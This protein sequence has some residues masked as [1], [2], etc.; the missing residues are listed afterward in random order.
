M[1]T[2]GQRQ[3]NAAPLS[4]NTAESNAVFSLRPP[5]GFFAA[6]LSFVL[7]LFGAPSSSYSAESFATWN[8]GFFHSFSVADGLSQSSGQDILQDSL[9]RLWI[10]TQDGLN[11]FTGAGF[12]VYRKEEGNPRS[13]SHNVVMELFED[14]RKELWVGTF[15]G[16]LNRYDPE[17]DS[18]ERF[19]STSPEHPL[20]SDMVRDLAE[21][22]AGEILVAT[23]KGLDLLDPKE[24]K[25]R[26]IP[27]TDGLSIERLLVD[28]SGTVWMGCGAGLARLNS[29][30]TLTLFAP[31][32]DG[33][34]EVSSLARGEGDTLIVVFQSNAMFLF[35][36]VSEEFLPY[37]KRHPAL[38]KADYLTVERTSGG[39][40][41]IGSFDQ[42][43]F[44]DDGPDR[45]IM[46]FRR[47]PE[48]PGSIAGNS[49]RRLYEAPNGRLWV[50]TY[51]NGVS[52]YAPER[53]R[54]HVVRRD[55][56]N[57]ASLLCN[58][59]RGFWLDE[60]EGE[61][62]VATLEGAS[63]WLPRLEGYRTYSSK[64]GTFPESMSSKVRGLYRASDGDLFIF[65]FGGV[66]LYDEAED[67]FILYAPPAPLPEGFAPEKAMA[68]HRD[69]AG[70][71]WIATENGVFR[72]GAN[73]TWKRFTHDDKDPRSLASNYITRFF[74]ERSGRVWISSESAGASVWTPGED[75]FDTI[76]HRPDTPE[77]IGSNNI[78]SFH[79][80]D[81]AIWLGTQ[82]GGLSRL[83]KAT[84]RIR[85]AYLPNE[86]IYA[87]LPGD[88]DELWL[89]TNNGIARFDPRDGSVR[90]YD[91][92]D[93]A[94]SRE[95]N[96]FAYHRSE[97]G[98]LFLGGVAGFNYFRPKD[99][100]HGA[101]VFGTVLDALIVDGKD[102]NEAWLLNTTGRID[103]SWRRKDLAFIYSPVDLSAGPRME[104]QTML[105]GY[106]KEWKQMGNRRIAEYTNLPH[107][108]YVFRIKAS[109]GSGEWGETSES[110]GIRIAAPPWKNP[111][112][113]AG[114][115]LGGGMLLAG[116][117]KKLISRQKEALRKAEAESAHFEMIVAE[118]TVALVEANRKL[119][120][121]ASKDPL[122]GLF[123]R[124]YFDQ[125]FVAEVCRVERFRRPL[126]LIIGDIDRF[127]LFNDRE[128]HLI[129]DRVL[130][131]VGETLASEV[132]STDLL[133]RWGGEEFIIL[134]PETGKEEAFKL[135]ERL[136]HSVSNIE[137][138]LG[139]GIAMSFG[140]A[141]HLPGETG[142]DFL[143]RADEA[144]LQAK[145]EG[146]DRVVSA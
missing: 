66:A 132:R 114:Y 63:R 85:P 24:K 103:L 43:L 45:P 69:G 144:L 27:S 104:F 129:G 11:R 13:L 73:G 87:I 143:R 46:H 49:I 53:Q 29:D 32:L 61:L 113:I 126:A 127:K 52:I 3:E 26:S 33:S 57:R 108:E 40:I 16:G 56:D 31:L 50:G 71:E 81:D 5:R 93:G 115:F 1:H 9:G 88:E 84:G 34:R 48:Y 91:E 110:Y 39:S 79:E 75:G 83:D 137:K 98:I 60:A 42:G 59:V 95:F 142:D 20:R 97:R 74:E 62:W 120:F 92:A 145:R 7:F 109:D 22:S 55:P 82:G 124:R 111:W 23:D 41:W 28:A 128:G 100:T 25:V 122:T 136:R 36:P 89:S 8:D 141:E 121:L 44:R 51:Y 4:M 134:L 30:E 54:F 58:I 119:A 135:A 68:L 64:E 38:A 21:N 123:N 101:D 80:T 10:G 102:R 99:A 112:A 35:D 107:G 118:R 116:L 15:L 72:L 146:R 130:V 67:R 125:V 47:N 86:T 133:A 2:A 106:D 78:F 76:A 105:D 94:Q 131:A 17:S 14:S 70:N 96:N 139:F 117:W 77:S 138:T 90:F 65:S 12:R 37:P 6:C 140:I 18:F 19:T